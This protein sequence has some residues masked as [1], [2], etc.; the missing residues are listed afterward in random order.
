MH[1]KET[2]QKI[3]DNFHEHR[4]LITYSYNVVCLGSEIHKQLTFL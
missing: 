3:M 4:I 2:Y 1:F